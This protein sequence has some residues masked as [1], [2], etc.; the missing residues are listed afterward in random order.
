MEEGFAESGRDIPLLIGSNLNEWN[1]SMGGGSQDEEAVLNRLRQSYGDNAEAILSAFQTAYPDVD[2]SNVTSLDTMLRSPLLKISAH[3]ADQGGAPVYSYVMTYGA[4]QAVH[5]AE[6]PLIFRNTSP[7]NEAMSQTMSSVWAQFART[8]NP[9]VE[10]LPDW[11]PF[12]RDNGAVMVLD[13]TSYLSQHH[14]EALMALL[15][16]G[17]EW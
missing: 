14:D 11:E 17:Y 1:F 13:S 10:G 3:K 8:G 2:V 4:P 16:P 6:I 7:E 12:T 15:K 5:G 9:S